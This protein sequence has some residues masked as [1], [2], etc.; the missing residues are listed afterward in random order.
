M[1]NSFPELCWT[2]HAHSPTEIHKC[3]VLYYTGSLLA[4]KFCFQVTAA[5]K[6][7]TDL[8]LSYIYLQYQRQFFS[9]LLSR[10]GELSIQRNLFTILVR[11]VSIFCI[12]LTCWC[13]SSWRRRRRWRGR[14]RCRRWRRNKA[15]S[16]T[17]RSNTFSSGLWLADW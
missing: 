1:L 7:H 17:W 14:W 13:K 8:P 4:F 3:N 9:G 10:A 2:D 11:Q 15:N 5:Q 12:L 16:R 6:F